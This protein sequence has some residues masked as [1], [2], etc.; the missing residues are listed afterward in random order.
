[1]IRSEKRKKSF[2]KKIQG[3]KDIINFDDFN[4]SSSEELHIIEMKKM[5][6]R[7]RTQVLLGNHRK[8]FLSTLVGDN[9]N[10]ENKIEEASESE[11]VYTFSS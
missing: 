4:S 2:I 1:M 9:N 11:S 10:V 3:V 6:M 7:M 8:Q 5:P